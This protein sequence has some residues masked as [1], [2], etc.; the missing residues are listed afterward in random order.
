MAGGFPAAA[1]YAAA[2]S[3]VACVGTRCWYRHAEN[4]T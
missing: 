2:A 3:A 1:V 4:E